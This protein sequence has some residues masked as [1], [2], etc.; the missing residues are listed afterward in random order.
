MDADKAERP[1]SRRSE[2]R[3]CWRRQREELSSHDLEASIG[4]TPHAHTQRP[5]R[6]PV[7]IL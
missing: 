3:Q 1:R 7:T 2:L 5:E 4:G 6:S